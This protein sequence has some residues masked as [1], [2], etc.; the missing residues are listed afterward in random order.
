MA[1]TF[2]D[3]KQMVAV[4]AEHGVQLTFNHQ[5]RFGKQFSKAK[6]LAD[7][8]EIGRLVRLESFTSNLYDWGTHWFD[9]MFFYNGDVPA[10]WVIGQIDARGGHSIFGVTVEGQ[11][12]SFWRWRNGVYGLMVTGGKI[13]RQPAS[14]LAGEGQVA[15]ADR[16][17]GTAP[18]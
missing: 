4:C 3:A 6:A 16:V 12:L 9:M 10:E 8:G 14:P 13:V 7:A 17:N 15:D 5:R 2:G 1:T 18:C 11:G